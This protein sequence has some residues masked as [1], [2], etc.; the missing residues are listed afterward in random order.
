MSKSKRSVKG[1]IAVELLTKF[2]TASTLTLAKKMYKDNP[3][4]FNDVEDAR[5]ILKYYSGESGQRK[6]KASIFDGKKREKVTM[7]ESWASPMDIF[8][9]PKGYKKIGVIS[10]AQAPFHDEKAID[11]T[12]NYL[13][14][15]GIDCLVMNG[16]MIDFY[17][18]SS[19]I[20]DPRKRNFAQERETCIQLLRYIRQ[21]LKCPIYY[22]LDANHEQRYERYMMIKAPEFFST[23]LFNI[24][25][26]MMLHDIGMIP[27][28]GYSH[29]MAGKLAILHGHTIFR[30]AV[31]P[32]SPARTVQMKLNQSALVSHVHKKSQYTWT[33]LD[34]DNHST[35]TTGCLCKIG[36]AVDY[37]PHGS[38]YVHGFAYVEIL[39]N[40]GM[41]AV[42][43]KM[44]V[45]GKVV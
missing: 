43:N 39:D 37:A 18:L 33:T 45:N 20:K 17:G 7:P 13:N 36:T 30:G 24:E 22:S 9:I 16:D 4:V 15:L 23:N 38:N 35:W 41:Y 12:L 5:S 25:D 19:F 28:R 29:I 3:S 40:S 8:T 6:L 31:S 26:L 11:I 21:S 42:E 32:V 34:G 27:L 10:D 1:E 2:P 44:I 14:K